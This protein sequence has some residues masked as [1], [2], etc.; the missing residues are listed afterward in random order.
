MI[1]KAQIK[2]I[3]SLKLKKYRKKHNLFVVEGKKSVNDLLKGGLQAYHIFFVEENSFNPKGIKPSMISKISVSEMK[4]I[5]FLTTP[6]NVLALF[7]IPDYNLQE[8][9]NDNLIIALDEIQDPGNLG[10]II[11]VADWF[12]IS[13]IICSPASADIYNPKTVQATMGSIARV[14]VYYTGLL[15]YLAKAKTKGFTLFGSFMNG[16][17][18]YK[19]SFS[20][21]KVLIM[22]NEGSGI[23]LEVEKLID[24]RISIPQFFETGNG[25]ESLNVAMATGI[26]VSEIKRAEMFH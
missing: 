25:P 8:S 13:R 1:S 2:L 20:E 12:G 10:T 14:K 5:S 4:K 6:S 3:Q 24:K 18:I 26:I 11:R 16:S 15:D 9:F 7:K 19:E 23:S 21:K 22:E 17:S